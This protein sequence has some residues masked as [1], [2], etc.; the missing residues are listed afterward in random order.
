MIESLQSPL[1]WYWSYL[2]VTCSM[3]SGAEGTSNVLQ[4]VS[5]F[6]RDAAGCL[7]E[8]RLEGWSNSNLATLESILCEEILHVDKVGAPIVD[9]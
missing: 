1:L 3:T 4:L 7:H 8:R 9:M 5:E 2:M 6:A